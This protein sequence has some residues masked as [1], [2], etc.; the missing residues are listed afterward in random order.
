MTA[1]PLQ[2]ASLVAGLFFA[3]AGGVV[4]AQGASDPA[5]TAP[6][7]REQVKMERD[8]FMRTHQWDAVAENWVLK[9]GMEAPAGMKSRAE[10]KAE[11][12]EFLR[13]HRWNPVSGEWNPLTKAP[14]DVS[15]MTRAQVRKETIQFTRTHQWDNNKG[16]W[17]EVMPRKAKK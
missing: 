2:A 13:N 7:A 12:N 15:K 5:A 8:E 14:R 10:V 17:V 9:P 11:R 4:Q 6:L 16:A 1:Y 3:L